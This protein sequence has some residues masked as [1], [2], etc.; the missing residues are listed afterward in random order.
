VPFLNRSVRFVA[1]AAALVL[2]AQGA[3][4]F[5]LSGQRWANGEVV[6]HLQLGS[7]N[8]TLL[9]G[10]TSWNSV[11]ESALSIWNSNLTNVRFSV[12]RDS[13]EPIAR[14]NGRNNVFW[15]STV[16][17]DAWDS[18][19]LAIT[20]SSYD[21]RTSR[22]SETDVI[23]NNTVAWNS[24]RGALRTTA[25][26][27]TLHDFR[28]VALHEFGHA[29]GLDH[30]DDV[31][32]R[33]TAIMNAHASD[34]DNLASDDISGARAIYDN[35][36]TVPTTLLSMQGTIGYSTSGSTMNLRVG[37]VRNDGDATSR[38]LRLELWAMPQHFTDALPS[39]SR[40]LGIYTFPA[41]L[42]PN[43]E[44]PNVN[45][46]TTYTAPPTGSYYVVMLL[47]EFTGG[48]GSGY[49]IRDFIEFDSV[50]N[51]GTPSAPVITTQPAG[52]TVAT[53]GSATFAVVAAGALP[54]TYQ[55]RKD[56][57]AITGAT[58]TILTISNAQ[59]SDAGNYTVVV[60]NSLGT[61]TSNPAA[62][63]VGSP[64]N[65]GRLVNM[66]IRTNAGTGDNTLIVGVALGGADPAGRK[67]VLVRAVGPTLGSAFNVPGALADSVL[68]VFQG[69]TQ[70]AQNDDWGGGFDF[71]SVGAFDLAGNPP[72][73]AAI[74]NPSLAA[75]SY[76]I[77]I[78]GKNNG[79][80]IA[81]AEI[82]DATPAASFTAS[83]PRLVNVSAR[84][85]VGTGDNILI[86]G[87][88][89]G[90]ST[91]VRV[92]VR[93]VG[94]TLGTTFNVGGALANP[95]LQLFNASNSKV[96][97]NDDWGGSDEL[98]TTFKSVGA[99]AFA[100]DNSRDAALVIRLEPGSYTAQISGVN[101]ATGVAL[102]E[103][104]EL[105]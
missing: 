97:E 64:T 89:I 4:G 63:F 58:S 47:T 80:G 53:G 62:L 92:L 102:V 54:R 8:G 3:F 27:D 36:N 82:Y 14:N 94:P 42:A 25:S 6:M 90:G 1:L 87:F 88:V 13:T 56:G 98:K 67:A 28:R 29:L 55:W 46:N 37:R 66:S 12:V 79:T 17:G 22:Y 32:Q 24:Y 21:T 70:I 77:Q 105:P 99:F 103:V 75:G 84:T 52:V 91:P 2:A 18:S 7:A 101:N 19:T 74:Y 73:D 15:S 68:T 9:D 44:F 34:L 69:S 61:A 38:T 50:L 93:A 100:A 20:L 45:V 85:Q 76:S 43:S 5:S 86:A 35:P 72:R 33:V 48:S 71:R 41:T 81:L 11:A 95:K 40:A 78:S 65:P 26:G 83:T 16:Y 23:F 31:G 39:G 30:P 51:I 60:T 104:Y 59:A 57:T 10:A 49:A 96:A